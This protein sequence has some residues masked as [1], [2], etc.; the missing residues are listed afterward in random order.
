MTHFYDPLKQPFPAAGEPY[1][2]AY[3]H[4]QQTLPQ[5]SALKG[6]H[7]TDVAVIGGGFTGMSTALHLNERG[8]RVCLIDA[9]Q[10]GWGCASRN[11]GF[12]L[13]GTGRLS[14]A[15]M[16]KKWGQQQA[17]DIYQEF[18][19]GIRQTREHIALT[20]AQCQPQQG[21]YLKLAHH[22][23][24]IAGFAQQAELLQRQFND[25]VQ[26]L[27]PADIEPYLG[28][29]NSHG[30][31]YFPYSFGI[32]PAGLAAAM[33]QYL[34]QHGVSLYGDTPMLSAH[35]AHGK[36]KINT[37]HGSIGATHLVIASNAY[38]GRQ[39]H[40]AVDQ[41]HFPVLSSVIV[42][43]VLTEQQR[44]QLGMREGL[45]A[46]DTRELKYYYRL[47]PDNRLLFGGRGAISG[48]K[49]HSK[50]FRQRLLDA[51]KSQFCLDG[52]LSADYFWSGWVSVALDDYPRV[53]FDASSHTGYAMGY[54]GS[55]VAFSQLAGLRM[56]QQ[57]NQEPVPDLPFYRSQLPK[58]P[59]SPFRRAG[60]WGFYQWGRLRDAL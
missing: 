2:Q 56:A 36:H 14:L 21:G 28:Q 33:S 48:N 19:A 54:C 8:Y 40:S 15:Q 18:T 30:A 39:L 35:F 24:Y 22:K 26:L 27:D 50:V 43:S 20:Q 1:T 60:L 10:P 9:A 11:A 13:P 38:S 52:E 12:V 58:F 57:I 4:H 29:H 32:N 7:D 42:T 55:G 31:L 49:A 5:Y 23:R 41:R 45:L 47:L 17:T 51:L 37:P 3:W 53:W 46:M 25:P 59:L 16:I 6:H 34:H 44:M